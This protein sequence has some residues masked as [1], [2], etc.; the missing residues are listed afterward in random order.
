MEGEAPDVFGR[1]GALAIDAAGALYVADRAA[2]EIRKFDSNGNYIRSIG[3]RG[4]G[5]GE[6]RFIAGLTWDL[7]NRLWVIDPQNNRYTVLDST[8][9]VVETHRRPVRTAILRWPGGFAQDGQLFEVDI[10]VDQNS[11]KRWLK[12]LDD[13]LR[14]IDSTLIYTTDWNDQYAVGQ[15]SGWPIPFFPLPKSVFDPRGFIWSGNPRT[16]S[17][18][19]RSFKGDTLRIFEREYAAVPVSDSERADTVAWMRQNLTAP[20]DP[21]RIP[22]Y[23]PAYTEIHVDENGF[24]RVE[25]SLP[26]EQQGTSFDV[27]SPSGSYLGNLTTP[28]RIRSSV[29]RPVFAHGN[30]YGVVVGEFDVE[31]VFRFTITKPDALSN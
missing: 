23:K 9:K 27:F 10:N 28:H 25:P 2:S 17:I 31:Y 16:Y 30:L 26:S 6:Y 21:E 18:A 24:L 29:A 22:P 14:A 11:T 15:L 3:H 19:Q 7:S 4:A 12:R 20:I 1:I 13:R 5:P 8:G